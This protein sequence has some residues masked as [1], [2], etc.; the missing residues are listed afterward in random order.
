[1]E[2]SD[3]MAIS[4]FLVA[5]LSALYARWTWSEAKKANDISRVNS[6][7]TLKQHY[8]DLLQKEHDKSKAWLEGKENKVSDGY[9]EACLN[10]AADYQQKYR[11]VSSQLE[12]LK[13]EVLTNET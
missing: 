4:A 3:Y 12:K 1:M 2:F 7:L 6:L 9:T 13:P 10:A 11:Q 5:L 8:S